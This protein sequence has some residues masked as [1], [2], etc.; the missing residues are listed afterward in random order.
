[1]NAV[2]RHTRLTV[3]LCGSLTRAANDLRRVERALALAGHLVHAPCP[4]LPGD[5]TATAEQVRR[6]ADRHYAAIDASHLVIGIAPDGRPGAATS[7]EMLYAAHVA[8][9]G[10]ALSPA[11]V[12]KLIADITAGRLEAKVPA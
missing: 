12:N 7:A 11:A 8:R 4:P 10:W 1:M 5:P 6:L 3:T 2:A 9:I